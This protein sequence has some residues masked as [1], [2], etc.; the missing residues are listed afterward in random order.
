MDPV[1]LESHVATCADSNGCPKLVI[2]EHAEAVAS[3]RDGGF[4]GCLPQAR[5]TARMRS[6]SCP[7]LAR[8]D[9]VHNYAGVSI[10]GMP[11]KGD[12]FAGQRSADMTPVCPTQLG[13]F[14]AFGCAFE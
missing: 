10:A 13:K 8:Q 9:G 1:S 3:L 2:T 4:P 11:A 12:V 5:P 6:L 14:S 7:P